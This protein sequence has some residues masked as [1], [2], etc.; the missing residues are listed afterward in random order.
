MIPQRLIR[1]KQFIKWL[2]QQTWSKWIKVSHT[3]SQIKGPWLVQGGVLSLQ[4]I[5]S[6][7]IKFSK[8]FWIVL[9]ITET[10][11]LTPR[12]WNLFSCFSLLMVSDWS[13]PKRRMN[14]FWGGVW[15]RQLDGKNS[16]PL[17]DER[18]DALLTHY[19]SMLPSYRNQ[20]IDLLVSIWGQL[21]HL[22]G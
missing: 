19:V 14:R 13:F 5:V 15:Q 20:S 10:C 3:S 9:L 21:Q 7:G 6:C 18:R 12:L 1:E 8:M 16:D 11:L 17:K 4:M 2:Y 22:M